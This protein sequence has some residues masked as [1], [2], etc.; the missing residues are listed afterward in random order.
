MDTDLVD[1]LDG[2]LSTGKTDSVDTLDGELSNWATYPYCPR[3]L[4]RD[5]AGARWPPSTPGTK[6]H[7]HLSMG[8][9]RGM[10]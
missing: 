10:D 9:L 6:A 5:E 7:H 2:E 1:S 3:P 4:G 8:G